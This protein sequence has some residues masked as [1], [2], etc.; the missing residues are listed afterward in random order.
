MR[1]EVEP[2]QVRQIPPEA[3]SIIS[4]IASQFSDSETRELGV[5]LG[6]LS[7]PNKI[8]IGVSDSQVVL[9]VGDIRGAQEA[10]QHA[11]H[12]AKMRDHVRD[13]SIVVNSNGSGVGRI[14][15][16]EF[17]GVKIVYPSSAV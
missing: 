7:P 10:A 14:L 4:S 13:W 15:E 6:D 2:V 12:F 5:L 16:E 17:P 3:A 11:R 1:V 8:C 9:I